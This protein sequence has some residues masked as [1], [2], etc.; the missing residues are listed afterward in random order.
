M[1]GDVRYAECDRDAEDEPI[2][3]LDTDALLRCGELMFDLFVQSKTDV[4]DDEEDT[5]ACRSSTGTRSV[6]GDTYMDLL[7]RKAFD[8]LYDLMAHDLE[9]ADGNC[10]RSQ[11]IRLYEDLGC[12]TQNARLRRM[13]R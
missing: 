3:L 9:M 1:L 4:D 10:Y 7:V 8:W 12:F 5:D 6:T 2:P 13:N 11:P